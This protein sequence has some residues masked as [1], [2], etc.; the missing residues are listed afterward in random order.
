MSPD[1]TTTKPKIGALA[2]VAIG[3]VI[4][5]LVVT[6]KAF[7]PVVTAAVAPSPREPLSLD[8]QAERINTYNASFD[9]ARAQVDGRSLFFIPPEPPPKPK[10]K[11]KPE[12]S[13]EPPPTPPPARYGGP[14][15]I[16]V[17]FNQVWFDNG[18]KIRVGETDGDIEVLDNTSAPWTVRLRWKGVEFDVEIFERTATKLLGDEDK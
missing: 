9:K 7:A 8:E 18:K 1:V 13:K 2:V 12:P 11:P 10:P 4:L 6:L 17:V 16:A 14:N 3:A 5:A 15:V